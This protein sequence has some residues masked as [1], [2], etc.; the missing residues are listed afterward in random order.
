MMHE[1]VLVSKKTSTQEERFSDRAL[2]DVL[3]K[4]LL[5]CGTI[6]MKAHLTDVMVD[7]P[8]LAERLKQARNSERNS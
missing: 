1:Q 4:V 8:S 3:V 7:N 5:H 2:L 6:E